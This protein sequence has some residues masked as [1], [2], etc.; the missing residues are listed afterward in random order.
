MFNMESYPPSTESL[1]SL[2]CCDGPVGAA[3]RTQKAF[4]EKE[5]G[6]SIVTQQ[7]WILMVRGDAPPQCKATPKC[8]IHPLSLNQG[9][10]SCPS[11]A[12]TF[13]MSDPVGR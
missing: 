2:V 6:W 1:S 9:F 7:G 3:S 10:G 5:Q 4:Q 12:V 8:S 13:K 11:N